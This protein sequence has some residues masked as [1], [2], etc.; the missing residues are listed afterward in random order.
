M[1]TGILGTRAGLVADINLIL[2]IAILLVLTI[3][4]FQ[5]KRR[6][7][8]VHRTLMTAV[9]IANAVL[10]VAIMNPSFFRVL[11]FALRHPGAPGPTVLWPH[12]L[13][14]TL[15]E[16]MGIYIVLSMKLEMPKSLRIRNTKWLMR[17]T[18]FLWAV[19]LAVGIAMYF[20]WYT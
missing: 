17:I 20:V 5:A 3:G 2:Q 16:L 4:I 11:P 19:A 15:A 7:F 10:I 6:N 18:F 12:I 13:I 14:G 1:S 8:N 9:V